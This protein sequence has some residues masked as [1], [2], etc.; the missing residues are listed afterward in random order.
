M[1]R[2]K[3]AEAQISVTS[4]TATVPA[5]QRDPAY[6]SMGQQWAEYAMREGAPHG[7]FYYESAKVTLRQMG[8]PEGAMMDHAAKQVCEAALDH[9]KRLKVEKSKGK[10]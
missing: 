6:E 9:W 2:V 5:T 3:K 10:K 1:P 7:E 8:L 4:T